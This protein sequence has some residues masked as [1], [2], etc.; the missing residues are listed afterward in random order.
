[1]LGRFG[2]Y[3]LLRKLGAGGMSE[4]FLARRERASGVAGEPRVVVLKRI[5][6]HLAH[7]RHLIELFMNE[8]RLATQLVAPNIARVYDAGSVED[9]DYLTMELIAGADL[10]H[11]RERCG[12]APAAELGIGA[13]VR[14]VSDLCAGLHHAHELGVV[15]GD[16]HPHNVMITFDGVAKLI[17][18]GVAR[19]TLAAWDATAGG[20]YAYMAPEQLRGQTCDRRADVFAVGVVLW[21]LLTGRPLFRR[22]ANYLTLTA[23]VEDE[24]PSVGIDALDRVLI[25]ALAKSPDARTPTCAALAA[26][27][28]ALA[29]EH[30]WDAG[31]DDLARPVA[32]LFAAERGAIARTL[33]RTATTSLDAWLQA[34]D[35]DTRLPWL[36][37]V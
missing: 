31:A 28:E 10:A 18:F 15:H 12:R 9:R 32:A 3:T 8:A 20:T 37:G 14:L 1:M 34:M 5:L 21:E 16:I 30:R 29:A 25:A 22:D 11:L 35:R 7:H 26:S 4:V 17:D 2:D 36:P 6:P 13:V 27:L 23:V 24:A 19:A 33:T